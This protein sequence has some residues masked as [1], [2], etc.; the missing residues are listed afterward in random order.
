MKFFNKKLIKKYFLKAGILIQRL[1]A[2]DDFYRSLQNKPVEVKKYELKRITRSIGLAENHDLY[3]AILKVFVPAW[4]ADIKEAEFTGSGISGSSLDTYRKVTIKSK[5]YFEKV[6]FN[7]RQDLQTVQWFE[8]HVFDLIKN[9]IKAPAIQKKYSGELLTIVYYDFFDLHKLE[10]EAEE[11]RLIQFSKDLCHISYNYEG[12][13][14][15]LNPPDSIENFR[16]NNTYQKY[17]H[18]AGPKLLKHGIDMKSLE[19]EIDHSKC[20]LTHSD[21]NEGNGFKNAVL[22]DWD[23]FGIYPMGLDPAYIYYRNLLRDQKDENFG[24]WHWLKKHYTAIIREEDWQSFER[25][26]TYFLFVFS[27]KLF[28]AGRFLPVEQQLIK[29]LKQFNHTEFSC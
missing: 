14:T 11:N 17:I 22:I 23:H 19:K 16:N 24:H 26:F 25:N 18:L 13:L 12:Y 5:H 10:K 29:K 1:P 15:K 2:A 21:I 9:K 4:Q 7:S 8:E 3:E 6:Y 28:A 20:V 27:A